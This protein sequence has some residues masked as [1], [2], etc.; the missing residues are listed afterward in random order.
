[1]LVAPILTLYNTKNPPNIMVYGDGPLV[2]VCFVLFISVVFGVQI[3]KFG[4]YM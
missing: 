3:V 2:L 4:N 1:M